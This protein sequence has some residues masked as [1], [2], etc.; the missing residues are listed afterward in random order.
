MAGVD[1]AGRGP[2][3]GPGGRGRGDPRRAAADPRPE[4]FEAADRRASA[5][6]C[7][8]DPRQG[9]VLL[10]S[11]QAS[12]EEIDR[13]TSCRPRC[14]R[15]G[16]RSRACACSRSRC[17]STATSCRALPM[18][19]EAIVDGDAKVRAISAASILAKVHR[20]RLCRELHERASAVRLRRPQGLLDARAPG[21]AARARRLRAP[22]AQLRAGARG[23]GP[24]ALSATC[25]RKRHADHAR[26]TTRCWCGCASWPASPARTASTARS[27]SKASTCARPGCARRRRR[28]AGGRHRGG[29]AASRRCARWPSARRER[30]PSCP[31]R[32]GRA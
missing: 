27:G 13:S 25:R 24:A 6:G 21:G 10:A 23:P 20:D 18:P 2:L 26:A 9:A 1:E 8:R 5:S 3:A 12:V 16:A 7:R 29:L 28:R 11:P 22:P 14:W 15:C 30:R 19:A 32:C 4:R 31:T 17:W